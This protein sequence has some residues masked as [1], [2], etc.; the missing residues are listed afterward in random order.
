MFLTHRLHV[1]AKNIQQALQL[2]SGALHLAFPLSIP[3]TG[4]VALVSPFQDRGQPQGVRFPALGILITVHSDF[5][6]VTYGKFHALA[7]H[8]LTR[9]LGSCPSK[10]TESRPRLFK[11]IE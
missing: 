8:T 6:K 3:Q 2:E 9:I 10:R 7:Q 11:M 4:Y 5:S 1:R